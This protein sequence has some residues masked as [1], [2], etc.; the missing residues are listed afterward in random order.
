[1]FTQVARELS[2]AEEQWGR[3]LKEVDEDQIRLDLTLVLYIH[4]GGGGG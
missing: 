4:T 2:R 3:R 1:M